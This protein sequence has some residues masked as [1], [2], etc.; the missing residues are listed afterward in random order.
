MRKRRPDGLFRIRGPEEPRAGF[1]FD[2]P[3]KLVRSSLV[4]R[5]SD[6][7]LSTR[8]ISSWTKAEKSSSVRLAGR[9]ARPETTWRSL[10][11][12][13]S[14]AEAPGDLLTAGQRQMLQEID[15][16]GIANFAEIR[17]MAIGAVVI[18]LDLNI[19][20]L[21]QSLLPAAHDVAAREMGVAIDI[22]RIRR[23]YS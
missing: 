16:E 1:G 18:S 8:P 7:R 10:G 9:K 11:R 22:L 15:V 21:P 19:V 13:E 2:P 20:A 3:V 4:P 12:T 23:R 17:F 14:R 6:R 5:V